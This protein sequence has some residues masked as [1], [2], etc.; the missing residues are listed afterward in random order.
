MLRLLRQ[1]LMLPLMYGRLELLL[2]PGLMLAL[3]GLA[4][5]APQPAHAFQTLTPGR[6]VAS[7][8]GRTV[9]RATALDL[10]DGELDESTLW[11]KPAVPTVR[12]T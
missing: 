7:R 8:P 11:W 4:L 3:L 9:L 12:N 1:Q 5:H 2:V 10:E 6:V